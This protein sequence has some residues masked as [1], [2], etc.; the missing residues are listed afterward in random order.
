MATGQTH[1]AVRSAGVKGVRI[2]MDGQNP[3]TTRVVV[4]LEHACRYELTPLADGKL[5]LTVYTEHVAASSA[6]PANKNTT[7][8]APRAAEVKTET[9][10]KTELVAASAPVAPKTEMESSVSS[11]K[12]NP[13]T[14][15][16][17]KSTDFVFVEPKY[18][19]KKPVA[20]TA[21]EPTVRA[22]D[23]AAKFSD[24]TAAELLPVSM[25]AAHGLAPNELIVVNGLQH[26][27]PGQ[28]VA[29]TRVAMSDAGA[30]LAQV[31][32]QSGAGASEPL[33]S[34]PAAARLYVAAA[35]RPVR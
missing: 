3:P 29:P 33:S 34:G 15:A 6:A 28:T 22:Q 35:V 2:G 1:I 32:A 18:E 5:V 23:A 19:A 25:N 26:V 21:T 27:R 7:S 20:D 8:S 4:D 14:A 11:P 17:A 16:T 9:A 24:K 13:E 10:P 31:A 30:G 12:Q